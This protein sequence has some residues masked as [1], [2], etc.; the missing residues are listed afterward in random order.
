[1]FSLICQTLWGY[2]NIQV[3]K[4]ILE[5]FQWQYVYFI[6]ISNLIKLSSV[7]DVLRRFW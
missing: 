4:N 6:I 1:M 7:L 3:N 5:S 2:V